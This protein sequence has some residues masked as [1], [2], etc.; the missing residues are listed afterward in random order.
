MLHDA[1]LQRRLVHELVD[2]GIPVQ[3]DVLSGTTQKLHAQS[4]VHGATFGQGGHTWQS[5]DVSHGQTS[6]TTA[7]VILTDLPLCSFRHPE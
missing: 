7:Y 1:I 4:S 6:S 2:G 5:L 3:L